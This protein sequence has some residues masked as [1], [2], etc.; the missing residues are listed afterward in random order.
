MGSSN[1]GDT[2]IQASKLCCDIA[3][4][5]GSEGD[6]TNKSSENADSTH[7]RMKSLVNHWYTDV[8]RSFLRNGVRVP[9]RGRDSSELFHQRAKVLYQMLCQNRHIVTNLK[10]DSAALDDDISC[11]IATFA[12]SSSVPTLQ[13]DEVE[14]VLKII[15]NDLA[16]AAWQKE[17]GINSIEIES[18]SVSVFG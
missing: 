17:R 2:K 12:L 10:V 7:F 8:T 5:I 16:S 15:L 11:M 4:N 6:S 14:E 1:K 18:I 13:S 3:G 9:L